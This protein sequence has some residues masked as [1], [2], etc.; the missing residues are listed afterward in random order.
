M[1]RDNCGYKNYQTDKIKAPE[2]AYEFSVTPDITGNYALLDANPNFKWTLKVTDDKNATT[3]TT[4]NTVDDLLKAIKK[5]SGDATGN[6]G[7]A[8]YNAGELPAAFANTANKYEIGWVWEFKT[9]DDDP[10]TTDIDE[11][12][13]QDAADT[14]MG[15]AD[16]LENII[17][18]IT[19]TAT[20]ID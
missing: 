8:K 16:T 20:Q 2:V 4:Y 3:A 18:K 1:L 10:T 12:T 11:R 13:A 6:T 7:V 9:T 17:F 19:V 15:N 5:L 14:A